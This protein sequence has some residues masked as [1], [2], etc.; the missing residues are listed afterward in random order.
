VADALSDG[1]RGGGHGTP[2]AT[3]AGVQG[4][5]GERQRV[6]P[7]A[8]TGNGGVAVGVGDAGSTGLQE[9]VGDGRV[10]REAGRPPEGQAALLRGDAGF[11]SAYDL[12]PCRDGKARRVEPGS[13]PLAHGLPGRVGLLRGYG[14]AIVPEVAAEFIQAYL[15]ARG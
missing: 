5:D 1:I 3:P 7:D 12:V 11:W 2:G 8:G 10:Q 9:R 14:N 15:E 13:F 4:A 6:R